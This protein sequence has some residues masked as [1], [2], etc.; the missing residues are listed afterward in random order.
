M[1]TYLVN[2]L[3]PCLQGEGPNIG[4]PSVLV[5]FQICNLRCSWCDTAYTHTLKSDLDE[6]GKAKFH[7]MTLEDLTNK[8]L[9][10]KLF[11]VILTG[12]EPTLQD[13]S[14]LQEALAEHQITC[15][16]ETNGTQTPHE[17]FPHFS[18]EHY[19]DFQWNVSPKGINAAE[20]LDEEPLKFWSKLSQTHQNV[21]FKF[22]VRHEEDVSYVMELIDSFFI[23]RSRV[24]LMHEGVTLEDQ[25]QSSLK[26]LTEVCLREKVN[27]TP[28]LHV[29]TYGAL[30]GV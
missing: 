8:I 17:K 16:V 4:K 7:R 2:E 11:H 29:I 14:Y 13:L 24:Y 30:R 18:F 20:K 28:R 27:L 5:R 19:D 22:V 6:E 3:Y 12:E 9:S 10:Y 15:E 1:I 23:P 26:W 21:F 25:S